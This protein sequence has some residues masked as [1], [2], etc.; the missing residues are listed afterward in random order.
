MLEQFKIKAESMKEMLAGHPE[1]VK[2]N[3]ANYQQLEDNFKTAA[4]DAGKIIDILKDSLKVFE[5]LRIEKEKI[6]NERR[7]EKERLKE[8]KRKEKAEKA[9]ELQQSAYGTIEDIRKILAELQV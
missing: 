9:T 6:E 7:T 3:V 2:Q 8:E 1:S 5:Q 4:L